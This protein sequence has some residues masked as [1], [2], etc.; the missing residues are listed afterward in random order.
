MMMIQQ[1][2]FNCSPQTAIGVIGAVHVC[3]SCEDQ[4]PS[5]D[6]E[7]LHA[8]E[9]KMASRIQIK[10]AVPLPRQGA[11]A[12]EEQDNRYRRSESS[13]ALQLRQEK[14]VVFRGG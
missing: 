1:R 12:A 9:T 13:H 5:L 11:R 2:T 8:S 14:T 3:E 4:Y 7:I 10:A 6:P